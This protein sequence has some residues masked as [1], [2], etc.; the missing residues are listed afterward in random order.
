MTMLHQFRYSPLIH[1][2]SL[3]PYDPT[4][5]LFRDDYDPAR[6][7]AFWTFCTPRCWLTSEYE[8]PC[9]IEFERRRALALKGDE[10]THQLRR[11][12]SRQ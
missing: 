10:P 9:L 5:G 11:G 7:E 4:E 8:R 6:E 3:C 2:P 1:C 12:G